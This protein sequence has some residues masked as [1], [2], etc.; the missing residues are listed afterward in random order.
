[1]PS[2]HR[3]AMFRNMI[4]SFIQH[5]RIKTTLAKALDL[6]IYA[7]RMV[8]FAKQGTAAARKRVSSF[9]RSKEQ[10]DKLFDVIGPRFKNRDGGYT[11]VYKIDNRSGDNAR[12]GMIEFTE[13]SLLKQYK[14]TIYQL[15]RNGPP[16]P[17]TSSDSPKST[18]SLEELD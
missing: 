9:V 8:T 2:G 18:K 17:T 13:N 5:E 10:V 3:K 4:T 14:P 1:M 16:L 6:R 15:R 12:M 11:R 7:D